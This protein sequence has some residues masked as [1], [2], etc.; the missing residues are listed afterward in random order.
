MKV[1]GCTFINVE[2]AAQNWC[3]EKLTCFLYT[4]FKRLDAKFLD[5]YCICY[6]LHDFATPW[7]NSHPGS[8]KRGLPLKLEVTFLLNIS[9]GIL[10]NL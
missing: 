9:Y 6:I 7:H 8:L 1:L 2:F 5:T 4:M 10:E 3:F